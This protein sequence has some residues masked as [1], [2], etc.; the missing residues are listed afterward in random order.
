VPLDRLPLFTDLDPAPTEAPVQAAWSL[1]GPP[2]RRNGTTRAPGGAGHPDDPVRPP[3]SAVRHRGRGDGVDWGLVRALRQQAADQL[4]AAL[5]EREGLD[6]TA[7]HELGRS[8]VLNLLSEHA[9]EALTMG[10]ETF[11]AEEQQQLAAAVFDALFGLGRLQPLVD[12]PDVENIEING[13]DNVVVQYGDGRIEEGPPVADSD[14]ELIDTLT[15]LASRSQS[16]E[17]PFSPSRPE[18]HLRLDDGSRLAAW[19]WITPRPAAVIRRHRLRAITLE[20][21]VGL[22]MISPGLASFLSAAVKAKKAIVVA[23]PQGAGKTTLLRALCAELDPWERIG[24]IETEH[25]LHLHELPEQH[26]RVV[27][28][29]ARPGSGER[30]PDGRPTGEI[31]VADITY[32]SWRANLSRLIVGEVRGHEILSMFEAMQG[33]AGSLSTTHAHSGRAAIERLVTLSTKLGAP[34]D[35]AYRQVAEHID[36][37]VQIALDTQSGA[38]PRRD[39]HVCEIVAVEPGENGQPAVTDVYKPGPDG[40]AVPG[41]LPQWLTG[42]AAHGFDLDG[43]RGQV[44]L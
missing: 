21:L 38:N 19:A 4:A 27:T 13:H 24:T 42:L 8:I 25:E 22:D 41:T 14:E 9:D 44:V 6:E 43:F 1:T 28:W 39:R 11:T 29:E 34:T 40:R 26:R 3:V 2:S 7:R 5:R 33:G 31:T 16:N 30:G 20:D 15:F 37:I 23:G 18:L 35:F 17:R 10:A 32:G 12:D 36:L